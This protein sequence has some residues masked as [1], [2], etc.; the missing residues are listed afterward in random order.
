MASVHDLAE[1]MGLHPSIPEGEVIEHAITVI[2]SMSELATMQAA[3]LAR[4]DAVLDR[5]LAAAKDG[6]REPQVPGVN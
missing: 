5:I 4:K 3:E 6:R 1:V 2:R